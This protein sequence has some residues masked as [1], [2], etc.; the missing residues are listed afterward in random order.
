MI[1]KTRNLFKGFLF[2][3]IMILIF[4]VSRKGQNNDHL[5][6]HGDTSQATSILESELKNSTV[7]KS[8]RKATDDKSEV[9]VDKSLQEHAVDIIHKYL[10]NEA[11]I[12]EVLEALEAVE[13]LTAQHSLWPRFVDKARFED[14]EKIITHLVSKTNTSVA[15]SAIHNMAINAVKADGDVD[16]SIIF[17]LIP[18]GRLRGVALDAIMAT[19]SEHF[20]KWAN[21]LKETENNL[22]GDHLDGVA[23]PD[24]PLHS[25]TDSQLIQLYN[26]FCGP[27]KSAVSY[28][29]RTRAVKED[30]STV[31]SFMINNDYP[32]NIVR[33][34]LDSKLSKYPKDKLLAYDGNSIPDQGSDQFIAAIASRI[35]SVSGQGASI[36]WLV[37]RNPYDKGR[38]AF[39]E[40]VK[41]GLGVSPDAVAKKIVSITDDRYRNRGYYLLAEFL[42]R[43]E[44]K[45]L[46]TQW[47]QAISDEKLKSEAM[48]KF[49][50]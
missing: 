18:E 15:S 1:F 49:G 22:D 26:A 7:K 4:V 24:H 43:P 48:R 34:V 14:Y 13:D 6:N 30:I 2:L 12:S 8:T 16:F 27:G 31:S 28:I 38:M 32:K 37:S 17:G 39:D 5:T 40:R 20:M 29:L 47:I 50:K 10:K 21:L 46:R 35:D 23:L 42:N 9:Y 11:S 41:Y 44:E 45:E 36:D 19:G 33:E 25:C 3:F